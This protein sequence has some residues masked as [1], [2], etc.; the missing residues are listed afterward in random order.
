MSFPTGT[1]YLS[2]V[3]AGRNDNYGGDFE[4]RMAKCIQWI[5]SMLRKYP[6]HTEILIVNYNPLE[7]R[8]A[9]ADVLTL[10]FNLAHVTVRYITVPN[11]IH[12]EYVGKYNVKRLPFLEY[13]AKNIGIK[14]ATGEYILCINPDVIIHSD[15]FEFI[16]N[17][18]LSTDTFYRADRFDHKQVSVSVN[19][20]KAYV[21]AATS[22]TFRMFMMAHIVP[23]AISNLFTLRVFRK[24]N[25]LYARY[26]LYYYYYVS[27]IFPFFQ[28]KFY[29][30]PEMLWHCNASGDFMLMHK[31]AWHE[32]GGY[33][34]FSYLPLHVDA[35][36]V[37][38]AGVHGLKQHT[39]AQPI[40]H[41]HHERRFDTSAKEDAEMREAYDVFYDT[42]N[43]MMRKK[44]RSVYFNK[45]EDWGLS[46]YSLP[47][48]NIT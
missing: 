35:T 34:E 40:Y 15:I 4:A 11:E 5:Q 47:E 6:I 48:I 39:F 24:L 21:R 16:Y 3:I 12:A 46:N 36:F 20:E 30:R 32:L 27:L 7:D 43:D 26:L 13:T 10:N 28:P 37:V 19:D 8:K 31:S 1:P 45:S 9:L 22:A 25:Q 41:Q 23:F 38:K 44:N 17:R 29:L 2:I 42:C 18:K 33:Q 14:R